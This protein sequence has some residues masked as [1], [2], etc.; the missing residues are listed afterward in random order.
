MAF[1][2]TK[3]TS[4]GSR[5]S[6]SIKGIGAGF[7]MFIAG[8]LFLWWNEGRAVKTTQMLE[9]AEKVAVH[10]DDASVE[11]PDVNG[12][13]IH[14]V[15]MAVTKDSLADDTFDV[16]V[17]AVR[18]NRKVEYYQWEEDSKTETVDKVGGS[19]E[20]VTTYTYDKE[21]TNSPV[22]S[23]EFK[24]PEYRKKNFVL[25][26]IEPQTY[27][28]KNVNLGVYS[29][30]KQLI[31]MVSGETP[32]SLAMSEAEIAEWNK[33]IHQPNDAISEIGVKEQ[34]AETKT[35]SAS[36][37]WAGSAQAV[38]KADYV[39][40]NKNIIYL[41][42][43]PDAPQVGDVRITFTKVEPAEVSV[44]AKVNGKQLQDYTAKNG[45]RLSV[46]SMGNISMDEMFEQEHQSNTIWTWV[47]R[48]I[49]LIL[50]VTGLKGIFNILVTLLKVLPFLADIAGL[51]VGLVCNVIGFIWSLIVIS[52]AWLFYR[53]VISITLLVVVAA[54]V[55]Y[56]V[57][58]GRDKKETV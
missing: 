39:H 1:Q 17:V 38:V 43:N 23:Q 40:I 8:T 57:K 20:E 26:N 3:T 5:L 12:K 16:G 41:G 51:G 48:F 55:V 36:K 56:L 25:A 50:V 35:D 13:L 31:S 14:V 34:S 27:M 54:G 11:N 44:L 45:K 10:V 2:E 52:I 22:N 28:A 7:V 4:Y 9:E 58:R 53:P 24:D 19:Q 33:K 49:G 47:F 42:K 29:L 32:V 18:L 6:G 21:W 46:L 37:A 15:G 30:S